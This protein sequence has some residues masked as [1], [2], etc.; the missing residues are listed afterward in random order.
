M[1]KYQIL[2]I[3]SPCLLLISCRESYPSIADPNANDVDEV[4]PSE[5]EADLTPIM[6]TLSSPQFS[7]V[8]RAEGG[9]TGP[10]ESW[11]E[12]HEHWLSADFHVFA[13]QTTN[14][15]GG[16]VDMRLPEN[17]DNNDSIDGQ[18]GKKGASSTKL[19]LLY[20]RI[21]RVSDPQQG[22]I[23]FLK[24]TLINGYNRGVESDTTQTFY[25]RINGNTKKFNF[26]TFYADDAVQKEEGKFF[27]HFK[28]TITCR[29]KINGRQDIMHSFAYHKRQD[30]E[31]QVEDLTGLL[32]KDQMNVLTAP[33]SYN[34]M[35]Y[36]TVT[37][38]R[39]INPIF[40]IRHLLSKF[41][42]NVLGKKNT[43]GDASSNPSMDFRN[44]VI[45]EIRF[46]THSTGTMYVAR[47]DWSRPVGSGKESGDEYERQ[48]N[49][50][51]IIKWDSISNHLLATVLNNRRSIDGIEDPVYQHI[52]GYRTDSLFHV[53][54]TDP[55]PSIKPILLPPVDSF[56]IELKGYF[57]NYLNGKNG[58]V[59]NPERPIIGYDFESK[60]KLSVAPYR[61]E[62]G[63]AYTINIYVYGLQH[64]NIEALFGQPWIQVEKPIEIDE[65]SHE[66]SKQIKYRN[67]TKIH[68][69]IN[70]NPIINP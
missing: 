6:P 63:K 56:Y 59:L 45:S 33:D 25:Y 28:D 43:S 15:Y 12:D 51:E 29:I 67:F 22:T 35:L 34:Q 4:V 16:Q 68:K 14:S 18:I 49:A 26:F 36:S 42:V 61:F 17:K 62:P 13:Y 54:S 27:K 31:R 64:I 65:D 44:I 40:R 57:L 24:D 38:H 1:N 52:P 48:V 2:L 55:T 53:L 11:K 50:G 20:D 30:Y 3:V 70:N 5:S 8:T 39:G 66:N 7:F 23:R 19:C 47:D 58:L 41:T 37:G 69:N 9:G 10:F 32:S 60:I 46:R 21:M